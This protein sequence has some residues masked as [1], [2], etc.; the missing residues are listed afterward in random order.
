M[1][2]GGLP[3]EPH[4]YT[5]TSLV[6]DYVPGLALLVPKRPMALQ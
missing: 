6:D 2:G 3:I 1:V 5:G 4:R